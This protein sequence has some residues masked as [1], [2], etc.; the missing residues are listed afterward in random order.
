MKGKNFNTIT[1]T[2]LVSAILLV[3]LFT[4]KTYAEVNSNYQVYLNG[5]SF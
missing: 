5:E 1:I 2:L 4:K 3:S